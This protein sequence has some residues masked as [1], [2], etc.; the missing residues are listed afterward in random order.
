MAWKSADMTAYDLDLSL[1]SQA[2]NLTVKEGSVVRLENTALSSEFYHDYYR[3]DRTLS[4]Q[5]AL[6]TGV[7]GGVIIKGEVRAD[8]PYGQV[9]ILAG[10]VGSRGDITVENGGVVSADPSGTIAARG[11]ELASAYLQGARGDVKIATGGKV[12]TDGKAMLSAGDGWNPDTGVEIGTKGNVFVDGIV[13]GGHHATVRTMD[14]NISLGAD[15]AISIVSEG[16]VTVVSGIKDG[17]SGNIT[18]A[19]DVQADVDN[20]KVLL[21]SGYGKEAQG[22]VTITGNVMA[23]QIAFAQGGFGEDAN[24]NVTIADGATFVAGSD[25]TVDAHADL[26]TGSGAIVIQKGASVE[27]KGA[28]AQVGAVAGYGKGSS[29]SIEVQGTAKAVGSK[30]VVKLLASYGEQSKGGVSVSGRVESDLYSLLTTGEGN[31]SVSGGGSVVA[32]ADSGKVELGSGLH[33]GAEGNVNVDGRVAALGKEAIVSVESGR[34]KGSRGN[35]SISGSVSAGNQAVVY[36]GFG[37]GSSGAA[38]VSGEVS[39]GEEADILTRS[40]S[41]SVDGSVRGGHDAQ[42]IAGVNNGRGGDI[43]FGAN[44]HVAAG[45]LVNVV[46]SGGNVRQSGVSVAINQSGYAE[47]ESIPSAVSAPEVNFNVNG[48]VGAGTRSPVAASGSIYAQVSGSASLAAANGQSFEGGSKPAHTPTVKLSVSDVTATPTASTTESAGRLVINTTPAS[49]SLASGIDWGGASDNSSIF[50]GGDLSIYTAGSLNPYGLLVAGRDLTVSA[51]SFGDLSYLRA[52]G[53]LTINNVGHPSH[54]QVAYFESVNGVEPNINNLPNDMVIFID[55][56]LAGGNL[57][58]INKFGATEAFPVSTPELKSEQGIFG[59]PVFLHGDLDVAN[60]M[61]VGNV[62]YMLQE[63]PRMTLASDFP[64]E[65]DKSVN[66]AG[67]NPKDIYRFGQHAQVAEEKPQA[68]QEEKKDDKAS[69]E[70]SAEPKVA[71]R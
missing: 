70:K 67:L 13:Q 6:D 57:N 42:L 60:P 12:L 62:D 65:V 61:A 16:E 7:E 47:V 30:G 5:A 9:D 34:G 35:V 53:K 24:G 68:E 11:V 41:I 36:A 22:D 37:E 39:A 49:Q 15:S 50:A 58:I 52:G 29:G 2:G 14:G 69:A 44:A 4:M 20:G 25:A 54:P 40:G 46:T 66:T 43:S 3:Y 23:R 51:A 1:K 26:Y 32:N 56:R 19:G 31:I 71:M 17:G 33:N 64:L 18:V 45:S 28:Y 38:L 55:G 8:V 27:A 63:I 48:N 10:G 59:N 21:A